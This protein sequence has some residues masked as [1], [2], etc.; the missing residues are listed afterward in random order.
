MKVRASKTHEWE[1]LNG[2]GAGVL[3]EQAAVFFSEANGRETDGHDELICFLMLLRES[4]QSDLEVQHDN[5]D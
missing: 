1:E 4:M 5:R 2:D 3:I